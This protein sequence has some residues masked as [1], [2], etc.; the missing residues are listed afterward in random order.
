MGRIDNAFNGAKISNFEEVFSKT[1]TVAESLNKKS[2]QCIELSRKKVEY[3]DAKTKLAKVYEK[4]G[5]IQFDAYLG[6]QTDENEVDT[7]IAEIT[8]YRERISILRSELDEAKSNK[9]SSELKKEAEELK[10]EVVAASKEAKEV[11][12]KQAKEARKNAQDVIKAVHNSV[13]VNEV[14]PDAEVIEVTPENVSSEE[15]K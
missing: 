3:L 11:F 13:K 8:A 6:A 9:D 10:Q 1:K 15:D 12:I 5:K 14:Q 4:Y 7:L 2:A